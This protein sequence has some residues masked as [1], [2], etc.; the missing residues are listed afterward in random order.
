MQWSRSRQFSVLNNSTSTRSESKLPGLRQYVNRIM[1]LDPTLHTKSM[2]VQL[3]ALIVNAF[4][5][6]LSMRSNYYHPF[7]N[8]PTLLS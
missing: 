7:H 1:E 6:L 3:P 5:L 4:Q 8:V 2:N